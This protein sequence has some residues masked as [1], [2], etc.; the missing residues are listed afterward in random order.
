[1]ARMRRR[2]KKYTWLPN[3]GN[4]NSDPDEAQT[5]IQLV[6]DVDVSGESTAVGM[7]PLL[8]DFPEQLDYASST[9]REAFSMADILADDYFV[10]RIVGNIF[11]HRFLAS[12]SGIVQQASF[13][14]KTGILIADA[15][16]GNPDLARDFLSGGA[17]RSYNPWDL[18]ANRQPWL[19]QRTYILGP[20]VAN[21]QHITDLDQGNNEVVQWGAAFPSSNLTGPGGMHQGPHVDIKTSRRVKQQER[22]YWVLAAQTYPLYTDYDGEIVGTPNIRAYFDYRVLGALRKARQGGSF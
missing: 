12:T 3:W 10:K 4:V 16:S 13:L 6:V 14:V 8:R 5:G 11:I 19:W 20:S 15:D 17:Q 2:K 18:G 22:L 9:N 1:M 21:S 7:L